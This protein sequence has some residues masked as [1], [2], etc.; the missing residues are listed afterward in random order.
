MND[1]YHISSTG[2]VSKCR[3]TVR[4]CPFGG[5]SGTENHYDTIESARSSYEDSMDHKL[6]AATSSSDNQ[7]VTLSIEGKE[8]T[9]DRATYD[10]L[11]RD[12]V[13]SLTLDEREA[14]EAYVNQD[15]EDINR[16]LWNGGSH[17]LVSTLDS[18][19]AKA[20]RMKRSLFRKP[21]MRGTKEEIMDT[22]NSWEPGMVMSFPGYSSTSEDTSVMIPLLVQKPVKNMFVTEEDLEEMDTTHNNVVFEM[23]SDRGAPVSSLSHM[24]HEREWLLPRGGKYRVET[25]ERDAVVSSDVDILTGERT[26][27]VKT[28]VATVVRLVEV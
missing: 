20:P 15:Y 28:R 27:D 4:P 16:E 23:I 12:Y 10:Q 1:R 3:A 21:V 6:L 24:S 2:E 26:D 8:D 22:V 25:V 17:K 5:D 11:S 9:V 14:V 7:D 19:L 18:A 13:Y